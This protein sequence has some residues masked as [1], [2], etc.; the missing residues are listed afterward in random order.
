MIKKNQTQMKYLYGED[1]VNILKQGMVD[2]IKSGNY[3]TIDVDSIDEVNDKHLFI[4]RIKLFIKRL[5][6]I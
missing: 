2:A 5:F 6:H 1:V 4:A 3:V